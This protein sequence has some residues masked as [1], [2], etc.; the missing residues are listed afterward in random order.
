MP[1]VLDLRHGALHWLDIQSKGNFQMNNVENSNADI[2]RICPEVI[3]YFD[4][5]LRPAM[6]DLGLLHLA[7]RCNRVVIRGEQ[8]EAFTRGPDES[9]EAFHTRLTDRLGARAEDRTVGPAPVLALLQHGDLSLPEGSEIYA[10]FREQVTPTMSA[11][12]LLSTAT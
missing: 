6:L 11:S 9:I 7:A 10:L 2:S 5:D 4:A 12:D 1:L 3:D 8:S